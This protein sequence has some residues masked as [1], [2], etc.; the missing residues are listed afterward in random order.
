[1][2]YSRIGSTALAIRAME[3]YGPPGL[4][5]Q[6]D[7]R[8]QRARQWLVASESSSNHDQAFRLLGLDWAGAD[9]KLVEEQCNA[10]LK[11]QRADGGW[12]PQAS[13]ESDAFATGLTLYA[14]HVGGDVASSHEAYQRGVVYLLKTQL[15]DGSWHVKTRSFPFQTYFESGF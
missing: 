10:L 3:L 2:E 6:L 12:S 11:A 9:K 7:E 5:T 14:L 1:L 8:R 4:K 15:D 13:M